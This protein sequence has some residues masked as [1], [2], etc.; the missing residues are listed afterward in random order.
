MSS[1]GCDWWVRLA[2]EAIAAVMAA[3]QSRH[4]GDRCGWLVWSET[5]GGGLCGEPMAQDWHGC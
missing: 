2:V 4:G 3:E 5:G 1:M